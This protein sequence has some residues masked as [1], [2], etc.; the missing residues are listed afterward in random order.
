MAALFFY[1]PH[2]PFVNEQA[3]T[4]PSV[5]LSLGLMSFLLAR[6]Q[7]RAA[8]WAAGFGLALKQTMVVLVPLLW[9]LWRRVAELAVG[10]AQ[11]VAA[12][13][14]A[15]QL[16]AQPDAVAAGALQVATLLRCFP[17][18]Q[19]VEPVR[20]RARSPPGRPSSTSG[21]PRG[22]GRGLR[23]SPSAAVL[24]EVRADAAAAV[25]GR[26]MM[27]G[28]VAVVDGLPAYAVGHALGG[29]VDE[30][31]DGMGALF[32][33]V[34]GGPPGPGAHLGRRADSRIEGLSCVWRAR[35]K[36]E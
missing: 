8:L 7:P 31:V 28:M 4:D 18:A 32:D 25:E 10:A 29:A 9:G 13:V 1:M 36:Q 16:L 19:Q 26:V 34:H 5:A 20:Y 35:C 33:G 24:G 2:A 23:P 12:V 27:V 14:V 3:W 17:Q 15:H 6:R 30:A 22:P 11:A 21:W